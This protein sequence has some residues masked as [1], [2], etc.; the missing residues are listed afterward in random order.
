MLWWL[1][2]INTYLLTIAINQKP[3][4]WFH[5][6]QPSDH[7][8]C[9]STVNMTRVALVL[10]D[11]GFERRIDV[12]TVDVETHFTH[13]TDTFHTF[14]RHI[15]H[16]WPTHFTHL[17]DTFHTFAFAF[18]IRRVRVCWFT[19]EMTPNYLLTFSWEWSEI[20]RESVKNACWRKW[21]RTYEQRCHV[22]STGRRPRRSWSP[23]PSGR[24]SE[25]AVSHLQERAV[26]V[27]GWVDRKPV[28]QPAN[29]SSTQFISVK[30]SNVEIVNRYLKDY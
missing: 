17:T 28:D 24:R 25:L 27:Y 21:H 19:D 18:T 29:C 23:L 2:K 16:I 11:W 8:S 22:G 13:L 12:E 9:T 14:D 10:H 6:P 4:H 1:Q 15:S 26:S 20:W 30:W 5:N 7:K 3:R